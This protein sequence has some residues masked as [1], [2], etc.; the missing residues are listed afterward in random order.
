METLPAFSNHLAEVAAQASRAV[1]TVNARRRV[2]STGIRWR[3]GVVVTADHTVRMDEEITVTRADGQVVPATL[4]GR[5]PGTDLAVL[6]VADDGDPPAALGDAATL[7]VG[8]LVLAVGYGPRASWG[9]VSALGGRW[10]TWRG[11][12]IDQ[13]IHPDLTLYPGFSGGPL[14]DMAG[15]VVGINTSGLSR[16]MALAI[17]AATVSRLGDELVSRGRV[18]RGYLGLGFQPVRLPTTVTQPLG[19]ANEIGLMVVNVEPDGPAGR[20]GLLLG[21]VLVGLDGAPT[22]DIGDVQRQLGPDRVGRTVRASVIRAGALLEVP[23]TVGERP[24]TGR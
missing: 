24:A 18:A 23:V 14:V 9:V 11:G 13:L 16:S 22:A 7:K 1:V 20:A 15:R 5:D 2:P 12:E 6:R 8:H 10:R 21:D 17:P 4:A 19:L 3:P